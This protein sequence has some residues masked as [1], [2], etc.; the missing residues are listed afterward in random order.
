[1]EAATCDMGYGK[2]TNP[3][4]IMHACGITDKGQR[5]WLPIIWDPYN[6]WFNIYNNN[7]KELIIQI[8][9]ADSA[10]NGWGSRTRILKEDGTHVIVRFNKDGRNTY[11]YE[12]IGDYCTILLYTDKYTSI[13]A[14]VGSPFAKGEILRCRDG[15]I[16]WTSG[17]APSEAE[18]RNKF[19]ELAGAAIDSLRKVN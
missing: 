4:D 7:N 2:L 12:Y 8:A 14:K 16:S 6:T 9:N 15:T 1:M 18:A 11:D 5:V 3:N 17:F 19:D 13:H 10:R